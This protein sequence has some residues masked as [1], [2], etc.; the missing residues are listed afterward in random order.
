MVERHGIEYLE[1]NVPTIHK[2]LHNMTR[3]DAELR[4]IRVASSPPGAHNLHLYTARKRKSDKACNTWLAVCAKGVEVYE[5]I[6]F[7]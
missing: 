2:D 5:V 6:C 7:Y 1:K 4:Y 3:N